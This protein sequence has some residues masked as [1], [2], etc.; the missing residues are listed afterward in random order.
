MQPII[1]NLEEITDS[2]ELYD[3]KPHPFLA[4]FI[5]ILLGVLV[6]AGIWMYFGEIDIVSKGRG[7][8]RPNESVSKIRSKAEGEIISWNLREGK[9]VKTGDS[10]FCIDSE[11]LK[12][13]K[14]QIEHIIADNKQQVQQ[15][16]KLCQSIE[17]GKNLFSKEEE[18]EYYQ[19]YIKYIQDIQSLKNEAMIENKN[20]QLAVNKIQVDKSI[21]NEQIAD[22]EKD[23]N[24]Y[25]EYKQS[26]ENEKSHFTSEECL[27]EKAFNIYLIEHA[28]L[29]DKMEEA[30]RDVQVKQELYDIGAISEKE[31]DTAKINRKLATN[32]YEQYQLDNIRTIEIK[33]REVNDKIKMIQQQQE[34]LITDD[35]LLDSKLEHYALA[36]KKYETDTMVSLYDQIKEL[37]ENIELKESELKAVE[38]SID[39]CNVTAPIDGSLHII[40]NHTVGDLI[41]AGTDVATI[42]PKNNSIYKVEVLIPNSEIAGIEVGDILKYNFDALPYKEYGQ[43]EGKVT[44]I[45]TDSQISNELGVSGYLVEATMS[46]EKVYSYKNEEAEVKVGMICEAHIVTDRKKILFALL[47]KLNLMD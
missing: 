43:L 30:N 26:I 11:Q 2:K 12:V 15:L 25:L 24:E 19:R 34:A 4:V 6:V 20:D 27:S 18:I 42:I 7:I 9:E 33:I 3:S 44:N 21:Y 16:E 45:S 29:K 37:N 23:L 28:K 39:N 14:I 31:L 32:E 22:Y 40:E 47:E 13:S 10:L 46:N 38:I 1:K 5:Y 8:V 17:Q 36:I 35:S 41:V